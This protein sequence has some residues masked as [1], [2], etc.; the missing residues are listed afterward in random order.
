MVS[1]T[2]SAELRTVWRGNWLAA[3]H[4]LADLHM[5][6][7]T[8]LNPANRNPHYSFIEYVEVYFDDLALTEDHGGYAA[9]I[10]EGLL[11]A[12]E[13]AVVRQLHSL[14]DQYKPPGGDFDHGAILDDPSW[15]RIVE[16]AKEAQHRLAG[17]IT[18][19]GE[20]A[21][22]LQTSAYAVAAAQR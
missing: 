18:E 13:A 7:A 16:A 21:R 10:A 1:R 5:Q 12:D 11:S 22:L 17:I 15:H 8:W 3:I 2:A 9:R 19:P 14:F 4:E 20:Q 6:R